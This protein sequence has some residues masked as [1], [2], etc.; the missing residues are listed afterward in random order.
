MHPN[1]YFVSK[2]DIED[3]F[4]NVVLDDLD[5][6]ACTFGGPLAK[7]PYAGREGPMKPL[8]ESEWD[9]YS[10]ERMLA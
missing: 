1:Y 3:Q 2:D 7:N 5:A 10:E 8:V 4:P 9:P 6:L